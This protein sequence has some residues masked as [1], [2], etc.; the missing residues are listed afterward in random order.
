LCY[1]FFYFLWNDLNPIIKMFGLMIWFAQFSSYTYTF[2]INP[3]VPAFN[4]RLDSNEIPKLTN[5]RIC[6][7]CHIVMNLD[8]NVEHCDDCGVCIEGNLY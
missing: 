5:Y 8:E 7:V 3:G 2:L 1:L 6:N 4:F